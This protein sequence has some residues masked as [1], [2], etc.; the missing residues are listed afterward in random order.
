MFYTS[1][2]EKVWLKGSHFKNRNHQL[3]LISFKILLLVLFWM[4][5][6]KLRN[7]NQLLSFKILIQKFG[8]KNFEL[9][10]KD[11]LKFDNCKN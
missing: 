4:K 8:G 6:D 3:L 1:S 5:I 11:A 2:H 9:Q 10:I 7:S